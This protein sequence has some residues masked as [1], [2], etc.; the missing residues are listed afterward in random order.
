MWDTV[1]DVAV[2]MKRFTIS[3]ALGLVIP[4]LYTIIAGSLT[5]IFPAYFSDSMKLFGENV[6]GRI[7]A[8]TMFPIY[9]I[10]WLKANSYFGWYLLFDNPLFRLVTI[11]VP[12]V[13]IYSLVSY[14][15]LRLFG[16][17]RSKEVVGNQDPPP[18]EIPSA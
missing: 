15:F 3:I 7:L 4:I 18:P 1:N 14:G 17:P 10:M 2:I 9:L 11:I 8:P 16:L 13:L 5:D 12:N 6:P